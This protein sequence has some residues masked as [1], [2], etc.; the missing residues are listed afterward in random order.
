M[1]FNTYD[2]LDILWMDTVGFLLDKGSHTTSRDG[3]T[4][5]TLGYV[6]QLNNPRAN[7]LF[8]PRR[9]L[10]PHYAAGEF[11]WYYT[12]R[13]DLDMIASYAPS[14]KRF[15]DDGETLNGAYGP[16]IRNSMT[17]ALLMLRITPDTRQSVIDIHNEED[18]LTA[19]GKLSK[20]IPCTLSLQ[21]LI[22]D[23]KL[24]LI[25]T[26]RSNDAWTGLPYD[27]F[28]FTSFQI[29]MAESLGVEVGWYQHQAGSMH[30][31]ERHWA[32]ANAAVRVRNYPTGPFEFEKH[33]DDPFNCDF[34]GYI[35]STEEFLRTVLKGG[36]NVDVDEMPR[37]S[38]LGQY[39]IW[40]C[41]HREWVLGAWRH[42]DDPQMRKLCKEL[43][44]VDS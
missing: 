20:D 3:D 15:S 17:L 19:S 5:E 35:K 25:V 21:F 23:G 6:V 16:R 7:F 12:G 36:S 44:N 41:L 28:C 32:S 29:L 14:Y 31:Y 4:K 30:L 26:M 34:I 38:M 10:K 43:Y 22:R 2:N 37:N 33:R 40:S 18:T 1:Q 13:E 42:I 39:L 24:N 9:K 27:V 8:N 11:L